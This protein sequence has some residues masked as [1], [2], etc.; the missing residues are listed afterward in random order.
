VT[1]SLSLSSLRV[2]DRCFAF[3]SQLGL[4]VGNASIKDEKNHRSSDDKTDPE[5]V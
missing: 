5:K 3:F 4:G 2:A 1:L